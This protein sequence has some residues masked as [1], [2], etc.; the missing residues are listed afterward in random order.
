MKEQ[1]EPLLRVNISRFPP[2]FEPP[3]EELAGGTR[4]NFAF[5][6][7][8]AAAGVP[9][10]GRK[11]R[12]DLNDPSVCRRRPPPP[13]R[14]PLRA[15]VAD[16]TAP[17]SPQSLRDG[18][19]RPVGAGAGSGPSRAPPAAPSRHLCVRGLPPGTAGACTGAAGEGRIS[20]VTGEEVAGEEAEV[21][22]RGEEKNLQ[23]FADRINCIKE[24]VRGG[25]VQ[26]NIAGARLRG[27][28]GAGGRAASP[29]TVTKG[30][31]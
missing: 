15:P 10:T 28:L 26:T 5:R 9:G 14:C 29:R 30:G 12:S 13:Q 31:G 11:L 17:N 23:L 20:L 8:A 19:P 16:F 2:P 21:S 3:C 27:E 18:E 4:L 6:A 1:R 22:G 24:G 7:W 25:C